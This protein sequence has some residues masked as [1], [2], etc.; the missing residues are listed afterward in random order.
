MRDAVRCQLQEC[1]GRRFAVG[2]A[3]KVIIAKTG[4]QSWGNQLDRVAEPE[5]WKVDGASHNGQEVC[6]SGDQSAERGVEVPKIRR[7]FLYPCLF[8]SGINDDRII[9]IW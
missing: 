8:I 5:F 4:A 7:Q 9:G 3:L 6:Q 2:D 1:R